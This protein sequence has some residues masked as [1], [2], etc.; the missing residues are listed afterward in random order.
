M[1]GWTTV[2]FRSSEKGYYNT[3]TKLVLFIFFIQLLI[4]NSERSSD[5]RWWWY[6]MHEREPSPRHMK[7]ST[8]NKLFR[9]FGKT[10]NSTLCRTTQKEWWCC[11]GCGMFFP[12]FWGIP[13]PFPFMYNCFN[14]ILRRGGA[15]HR[16]LSKKMPEFFTK[17]TRK[18]ALRK[19]FLITQAF[20]IFFMLIKE[21]RVLPPCF[22]IISPHYHNETDPPSYLRQLKKK[23]NTIIIVNCYTMWIDKLTG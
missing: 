21:K 14:A 5:K 4:C 2:I 9:S 16:D 3:N 13:P 22:N 10:V 6:T 18:K 7:A 1:H 12:Q 23:K 15:V 8:T 11:C 19:F 20:V 17:W